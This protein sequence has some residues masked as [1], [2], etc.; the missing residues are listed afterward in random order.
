MQRLQH[1]HDIARGVWQGN[2][3]GAAHHEVKASRMQI[4]QVARVLH[5]VDFKRRHRGHKLSFQHTPCDVRP[6]ASEL[7]HAR[8]GKRHQRVRFKVM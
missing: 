5:L 8:T 2:I 1:N 4:G 6:A 3:F 7:Y